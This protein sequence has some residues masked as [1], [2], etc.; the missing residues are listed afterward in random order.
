MVKKQFYFWAITTCLI[1]VFSFA[2]CQNIVNTCG[3]SFQTATITISTNVGEPIT[4][5]LTA[6]NVLLTQGFLQPISKISP[7]ANVIQNQNCDF[8][9]FPNPITDKA[10]MNVGTAYLSGST[11]DLY[12]MNGQL[13]AKLTPSNQTINLQNLSNGVYL[14][15]MNCQESQ[16]VWKKIAKVN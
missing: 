16:F 13:V 5:T 7:I 11:F 1:H 14:L 4:N 6:A 12:D 10:Q 2:D 8:Q 3:T 9:I 15:R